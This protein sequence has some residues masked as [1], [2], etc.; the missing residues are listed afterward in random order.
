MTKYSKSLVICTLRY[1]DNLGDGVIADSLAHL[2]EKVRPGLTIRHLDM[3]GRTAFLS[4]G[5]GQQKAIYYRTPAAL[6]PLLVL[7]AWPIAMRP[8][9]ERA[10]RAALPEGDFAL[11]FG[12][13]QMLSDIALNFPLKFHLIGRLAAGRGAPLA[14]GAVGVTSNWSWLGRRLFRRVLLDPATRWVG[15]RDATS[16]A[17][18]IESVPELADRCRL[19]VDPAVWASDV[20]ERSARTDDPAAIPIGLGISHPIELATQAEDAA[21]FSVEGTGYFWCSLAERL[22]GNGYTPVLFTNGAAE[23]EAFLSKVA[24]SLSDHVATGRVRVL[25]RPTTPADLIANL[26][27]LK[28]VVSHRLHANIICF[29]LGIP[30]VALVWDGKVR[31]FAEAAQR[32]KWCAEPR[33]SAEEIHHLVVGALAEGVDMGHRQVLRDRV[34]ADVRDML[35]NLE[36]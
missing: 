27:T 31:A 28:A 15:V 5:P 19:T 3:A 22:I 10:W 36:I 26:S 13:G 34:L 30:T 9:V 7:V 29:S 12:G 14:V 1:S 21:A 8:K 32:A 6:R 23:D 17:S 11:V 20:Y 4:S 35:S 16:R 33:A 25:P 24:G 18:I 2:V